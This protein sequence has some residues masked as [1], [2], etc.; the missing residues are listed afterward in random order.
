MLIFPAPAFML[1]TSRV[2][3]LVFLKE[4][5][6]MV[7]LALMVPTL[8]SL[9]S[10]VNVDAPLK[11]SVPVVIA[12]LCVTVPVV[13]A[14]VTLVPAFTVPTANPFESVYE[15]TLG[16]FGLVP[17]V[18]RALMLFPALASVKVE[19]APPPSVSVPAVMAPF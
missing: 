17:V 10:S 16:I 9:V 7:P 6:A 14:S 13:L 15:I 2:V 8:L 19:V 1:P 18:A 3:V 5:P 12:P 11:V 4:R